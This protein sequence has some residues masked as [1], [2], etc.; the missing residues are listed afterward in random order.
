[1]AQHDT[2]VDWIQDDH[3]LGLIERSGEPFNAK[4][5]RRAW[6]EAGLGWSDVSFAAAAPDGTKAAI[7]LLRRGMVAESLPL[8]YGGVVASRP[9]EAPELDSFLGAA[10]ATARAVDLQA[11]SVPMWDSN[12]GNLPGREVGT[13]S[14]LYFAPDVLATAQFGKKVVQTIGRARRAGGLARVATGDPAPFLRLYLDA[15]KRW[16][17]QYPEQVLAHLAA[18]GVLRFYD[19]EL[20]GTVEASAAG[21]IGERHWMYWLAAQSTVGRDAEFGYLALAALIEDAQASG[22]TAVNLGASAGLP[23]VAQFK[24]RFGGV[25]VP[26]IE[27]RST[28]RSFRAARQILGPLRQARR[29]R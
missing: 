21:L 19:V 3:A 5:Y 11:R 14:V 27:Q 24:K 17:M 16:A 20:N 9:L 28:T 13:T 29:R 26:V 8:G 23:G 12:G 7:A 15:S 10:R 18:A 1:V 2:G 22:A 6:T 4:E 25:D